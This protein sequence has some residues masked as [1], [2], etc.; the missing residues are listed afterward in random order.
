ML[1]LF[2]LF[3]VFTQIISGTIRNA[4]V[5]KS[6]LGIGHLCN[7]TW[8][9]ARCKMVGVGLGLGVGWRLLW[10]TLAKKRLAGRVS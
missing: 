5:D 3:T 6:K 9:Q 2:M 8:A 10:A 4:S 7:P 1:Q